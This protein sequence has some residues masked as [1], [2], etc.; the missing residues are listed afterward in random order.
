MS[1]YVDS[2]FTHILDYLALFTEIEIVKYLL[3]FFV[4]LAA[5]GLFKQLLHLN[6]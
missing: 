6:R 2:F 4:V 5:L 1:G 3:S